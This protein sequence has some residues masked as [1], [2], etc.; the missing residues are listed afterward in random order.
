MTQLDLFPPEAAPV[1][2]LTRIGE[3]ADSKPSNPKQA[4]GDTKVPLAF[5]PDTLSFF[6]ATAF[7][8][9]AMKYGAYN[10]RIAGVRASTYKS[11]CERHIKKWWNGEKTDPA[12]RVR[13]LANAIAC[14]GIILDAEVCG[15]LTDDRPP[16]V[17]LSEALAEAEATLAHLKVLHKDANPR[18]YTIQDSL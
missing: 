8:E 18:H 17:D 1:R 16:R 15:M 9:G 3:Y 7:A 13:H 14:L 12:T 10:W 4:I 2:I 6:A 11:A 5:V